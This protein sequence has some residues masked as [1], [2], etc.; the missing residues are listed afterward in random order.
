MAWDIRA[1][2]PR[3]A[4]AMARLYHDTIRRVNV[5]DY[6]P[7]QIVAW[8]GAGPDP[9]KWEARLATRRTFVAC[10]G[11]DVLG[12]A[13]LAA[14][15][16][17]DAVYVHHAHQGQGIASRLLARIEQ[18]AALRGVDRLYVE[19]SITARPFF[20]RRGFTVVKAQDVARRGVVFRNYRMEKRRDAAKPA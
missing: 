1:A 11:G 8:A 5:R 18:E 14:G 19:A 15:G 2:T 4:A 10:R 20:E 17:V 6:A 13:E 12:F 7:G 16:H 3:D 9:A